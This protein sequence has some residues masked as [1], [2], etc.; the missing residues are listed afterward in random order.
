MDS[1]AGYPL[2]MCASMWRSGRSG[3]SGSKR[4]TPPM[5]QHRNGDITGKTPVLGLGVPTNEMFASLTRTDSG[6]ESDSLC[7]PF[8]CSEALGFRLRLYV[9]FKPSVILRTHQQIY[10]PHRR[11][12]SSRV[13][14][15]VRHRVLGFS[16]NMGSQGRLKSTLQANGTSLRCRKQSNTFITSASRTHFDVTHFA[17]CAVLFNKDTF[18]SDVKVNSVYIH[19]MGNNKP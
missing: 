18:H 1:S 19:E 10:L 12:V 5:S 8:L 3:R 4:S 9:A 6:D 7:E 17:G 15:Q 2:T 16:V 11:L 14:M 13:R